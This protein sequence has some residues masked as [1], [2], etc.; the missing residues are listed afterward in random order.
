MTLDVQLDEVAHAMKQAHMTADEYMIR[1]I[2]CIDKRLGAGYATK[3]PELLAA[4]MRS[5]AQD[6]HTVIVKA[7]LQDLCEA[8]HA[9]VENVS[10]TK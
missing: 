10:A 8:L 3:H 9:F 6:F 7:G 1:G 5:A 2:Q 4:F